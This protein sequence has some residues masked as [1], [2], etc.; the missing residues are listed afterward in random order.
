MSY[1]EEIY[2]AY[3]SNHTSNLYGLNSLLKIKSHFPAWQYYYGRLLPSEP[4]AKI[5]DLGCGDGGFV[6]WLLSKGFTV[7][8][9][10]D[11]SEEQITIGRKMG[12]GNI[13]CADLMEALKD[14][15][16]EFDLII[17][18]DV[19]EHFTKKD[20]YNIL[21]VVHQALVPG[22]RFLIQVPNGEG[23]FCANIYY[24]DFT[25]ETAFTQRSLNQVLRNTGY[26]HITVKPVGPA[27]L[28]LVSFLRYIVWGGISFLW[29]L[30]KLI[31]TGNYKM[32][33]TQNIIASA[34]KSPQD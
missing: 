7:A 27:P 23:I 1:K 5:L 14:I 18:R 11:I 13:Q 28:G 3:V 25:H 31:E 10:I 16:D 6:Y 22:G 20:I 26:D 30:A 33:T 29:R 34:Q 4:K 32:I 12:I 19:L 15:K 9:G 2:Q 21:R 8:R 17:A 24:G